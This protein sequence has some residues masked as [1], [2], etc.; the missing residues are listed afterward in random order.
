MAVAKGIQAQRDFSAG[1]IDPA[2]KRADQAQDTAA[3]LKAGL[4][5]ASNV[6]IL[7]SKA[8]Q[9][10]PGRSALQLASTRVDDI[11]I[12]PGLVFHFNFTAAAGGSLR[13]YD[14]SGALVVALANLGWGAATIDLITFAV[15]DKTVYIAAPGIIPLFTTWDGAAWSAPANFAPLTTIGSQKRTFFY[16][17]SPR[18]VTM[19]PSATTGAITLTFSPAIASFNA[20]L[21]GTYMRFCGRQIL[22]TGFTSTSSLSG[23]V[24]E[25]LPPGQILAVGSDP[26][27]L[28]SIGDEIVG[29]T[30]NARGIVTAM[31]ATHITLQLL[32]VALSAAALSSGSAGGERRGGADSGFTTTTAGFVTPE[33]VSGPGGSLVTSATANTIP[34]AVAVWDEE[35]MNSF[36]GW[37]ASVFADQSRLGFCN[38]PALPNAIGW[39][40]IAS[41]TDC[42]VD[43]LAN[44]A[45]LEIAPDKVQVLYVVPGAESSEFVFCDKRIYYIPIT[46]T[47]P[48]K[49]GSVAFQTISSEGSAQVQPQRVQE[50]LVYMNAGKTSVM[51]IVATGATNRPYETRNLSE[52]HAHLIKTPIAIA[53]PTANDQFEERYIYVLNSD[54]TLAVGKYSVNSGQVVGTVG[55]VPWSGAGAVQWISARDAVVLFVVLY[56]AGVS[57]LERLDDSV[58]LD[59][60]ILTNAPP[61]A[62]IDV[63]K[64]SLWFFAGQTVDLMDQGTRMMGTYQVNAQ[65]Y[66]V[67]QNRGGE[68]LSSPT[69]MAG[70]SWTA[71]T[72]PF[73]PSIQPGQDQLQRMRKR[74]IKR[75]EIYVKNSTGFRVDTLK[76][77]DQ[78]SNSP[79]L[80][81]VLT[82]RRIPAWNQDDDPT[83]PPPSR[84][85]AYAFKP[86]GR[87]HDPR[88]AI[89]KDTPGP[90]QILELGLEVSV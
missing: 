41:P 37:P 36:R 26:R 19:L 69:L 68:D 28:F 6:R 44:S 85:Q 86:T 18:G 45:M 88:I 62:L 2:V 50:V 57:L 4:R 1:E 66:I 15:I 31:D 33:T 16:R 77:D 21:I 38:F 11:T 72:E 53:A 74:R 84:E 3:I 51:S 73:V 22:I 89:V 42:Y 14:T 87:A 52:L 7:N 35:V 40:A 70:K 71:A 59:G 32:Q 55:W 90:L 47:N 60:A 81:T 75:A 13:I 29:G 80:G 10:R 82:S 65:G 78:S 27:N 43:A 39:S 76:A 30:S 12:S 20:A 61:A 54:G 79:A 67:P 34:Q 83:L 5:Q 25:A 56:D 46:P 8:L 58:Y 48:L 64:G 49:P 23:T 17:L 9:N 24:A 63:T